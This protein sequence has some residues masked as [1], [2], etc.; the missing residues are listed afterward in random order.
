MRLSLVEHEEQQRREREAKAKEQATAEAG[1]GASTT[2]SAVV[3]LV[4]G[5]WEGTPSAA[6]G[7]LTDAEVAVDVA[8]GEEGMTCC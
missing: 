7:V 3:V 5:F 1:G 6:V 8:P 2:P 4:R